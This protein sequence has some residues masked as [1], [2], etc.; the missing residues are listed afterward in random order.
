MSDSKQYTVATLLSVS[1]VVVSLAVLLTALKGDNTLRI[2]LA[3]VGFLGFSGLA[4]AVVF[5][6]SRAKA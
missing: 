3:G 2:L 4:A 5:A 6:K 1:A